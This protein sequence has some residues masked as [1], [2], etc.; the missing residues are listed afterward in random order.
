M[1]YPEVKRTAVFAGPSLEGCETILKKLSLGRFSF[2]PPVQRNDI[3]MACD[4]Y[5]EIVIADGL[6]N[7]VPAVGHMEIR[8]ALQKCRILGCSSM[9]AIRAYEMRELGMI[10][11]GKA[12][13]MFFKYDDF[14]DAELAQLIG[15]SPHYKALTEPLIHYRY[16][17]NELLNEKELTEGEAGSLLKT[18]ST[19][20]FGDLSLAFFSELLSGYTGKEKANEVVNGFQAYRIKNHDLLNLLQKLDQHEI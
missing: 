12:Y 11:F 16:C 15:P 8:N 1:Q 20:F 19:R 17:I 4:R 9:G 7:S 13:H 14:T 3:T 6:F 18:L 5:N 2:F 10:G